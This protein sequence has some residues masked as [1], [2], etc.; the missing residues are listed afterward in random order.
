MNLENLKCS[1][2]KKPLNIYW[3]SKNNIKKNQV[4]KI[5]EINNKHFNI[6]IKKK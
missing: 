1:K 4:S 2:Y 5:L 3:K 6:K